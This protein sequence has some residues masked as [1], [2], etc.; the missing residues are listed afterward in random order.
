MPDINVVA[1]LV[2]GFVALFL[3]SIY[4]AMLAAQWAQLSDAGAPSGRP[5]PPKL[6]AELARSL[7]LATVI[8]GLASRGDIETAAG[9]LLLGVALWVGFPF[10]LWT[11]A[12]LWENTPWRLAALHAGDWLVKLLVVGVLVSAIQ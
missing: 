2:A 3:G 8:A 5:R 9:G 4:Y 7:L 6:A 1:V 12:I 11:G 10:V